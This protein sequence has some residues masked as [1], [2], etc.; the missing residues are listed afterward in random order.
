MK[1]EQLE[2]RPVYVRKESRTVG[3]VFVTML[4]Y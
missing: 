2:V 4:A 3:H 1:T